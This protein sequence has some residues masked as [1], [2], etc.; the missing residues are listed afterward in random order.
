MTS[1]APEQTLD[2][3]VT[4][5]EAASLPPHMIRLPGGEWP[6]WRLIG[7][8]GTGFPIS[9]LL[10]FGAEECAALREQI[11]QSEADVALLRQEALHILYREVKI[12]SGEEKARLEKA[13]RSIR[14][15]N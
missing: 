10:R 1:L 3:P 8:R 14:G 13:I 12:T 9:Q 15:N 4:M 6:L 2:A 5:S 11:L 7:L